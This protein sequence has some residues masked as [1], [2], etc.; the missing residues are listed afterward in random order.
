MAAPVYSNDLTT[1][2]T[3]DLNFDAGVWEESGDAGWDT[4]GAMVDDTNL[5]YVKTSINS[6]QADDS[7]TSAQ[8][9]KNGTGTGTTGPGTI[10]YAH[11]A[12]F[13]VPVDGVILIDDLWAAPSAL[14]PFAGTFGVAEAGVSVLIGND[15]S[16]FDVH[17]VSGSDKAPA[18][19][20]GWTTYCVDPTVT[21]D[22]TI[23]T[24]TNT[25][26]VGVAIAAV[27]QARGNPHACQSIRYGRGEVEYT[28]GE[29]AN[30]ATFSGYATIDN[31]EADRFNL[32]QIIAGGYKARGLMSF[33][34]AATAVYFEDSDKSIVIS[35]DPK[36][37]T[38]FNKGIVSNAG[39]VLKWTN[40][41][42]TNLS[43][44]AKYS[45]TVNDAA[46]TDHTGCVFTDLNTFTYGS[47]S[48]QVNTT[49]RRQELVTQGGST[50]SSCS[51]DKP[52]GTSGLS[53]DNL[54]IVTDCTFNSSGANYGGDLGTISA[55][56]TV[57]WDNK[58]AGH[59]SGSSGTNV[60]LTPT[61]NETLL[62]S[63]DSGIT[64]TVNVEAGASVP[65]VANSGLGSVDVVAG[66]ETLTINVTAE[67]TKLPVTQARVHVIA[68]AGGSLPVGSIIIDAQIVDGSGNVSGTVPSAGQPFEGLVVD[69]T[70]PDLYVP[71]PI[72]GTVPVGGTTVNVS[73]IS[74]E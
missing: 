5:Q 49:Y 28:L 30:P 67:D 23:G 54:G 33:G 32:L 52:V 10:M 8:Y 68:A 34:T 35:D 2:A 47:G 41:A 65:S 24:V 37:G 14:N 7:C 58:E 4:A 3:G 45:F 39:S 63:V 60:G 59:V 56:T 50:F 12:A 74:D 6:G 64:L 44:V 66:L 40:I 72:A 51:F 18:P 61:G 55:N 48:T 38:A 46:D 31:A 15:I 21:P 43:S 70:S 27:A 26:T 13:T 69:G 16:N 1:I 9:T 71:K 73:L 20:G 11:T 62:C 42:I 22:G 57:S 29:I 25:T 36:V 53:I 17:Y 19:E